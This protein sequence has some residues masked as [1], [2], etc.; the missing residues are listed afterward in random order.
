MQ[1]AAAGVAGRARLD[2]AV[3]PDQPEVSGKRGLIKTE[4]AGEGLLIA[5]GLALQ[6]DEQGELG[7]VEPGAELFVIDLGDQARGTAQRGAGTL[8]FGECWGR[9]LHRCLAD[10]SGG[11]PS[12]D[13]RGVSGPMGMYW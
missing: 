12:R 9:F 7:G 2:P 3:S 10:E 6:R 5:A 11:G 4:G 8:D 13:A 1:R